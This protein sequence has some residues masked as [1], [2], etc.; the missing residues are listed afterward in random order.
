MHTSYKRP[1]TSSGVVRKR[2]KKNNKK[3]N[4]TKNSTLSAYH[5]SNRKVSSSS[6]T[7]IIKSQINHRQKQ[8]GKWR[9]RKRPFSAKHNIKDIYNNVKRNDDLQNISYLEN[10]LETSTLDMNEDIYNS[11]NNNNKYNSNYYNT[12]EDDMTSMSKTLSNNNY[13]N[14]INFLSDEDIENNAMDMSYFT[15]T[16]TSKPYVCDICKRGFDSKYSMV[17]HRQKLHEHI[18]EPLSP[19]SPDPY[20]YKHNGKDDNGFNNMIPFVYSSRGT[21]QLLNRNKKTPKVFNTSWYVNKNHKNSNITFEE[22]I[23][24][25]NKYIG[26]KNKKLSVSYDNIV[27]SRK[28]NKKVNQQYNDATEQLENMEKN[29]KFSSPSTIN[30][31]HKQQQYQNYFHQHNDNRGNTLDDTREKEKI[32]YMNKQKQLQM[33]RE[34]E[35]FQAIQNREKSL[36]DIQ[37]VVHS[38][39]TRHA[40]YLRKEI[41]NQFRL[42]DVIQLINS[43]LVLRLQTMHVSAKLREWQYGIRVINKASK[44]YN[45]KSEINLSPASDK[46]LDSI[47]LWRGIDYSYKSCYDLAATI[48][49]LPRPLENWIEKYVPLIDNPLLLKGKLTAPNVPPKQLPKRFSFVLEHANKSPIRRRQKQQ[50]DAVLENGQ[51]YAFPFDPATYVAESNKNNVVS[52]AIAWP[53][54]D[55]EEV[56]LQLKIQAA[57]SLAGLCTKVTQAKS[58]LEKKYDFVNS[59]SSFVVPNSSSIVSNARD[60]NK[61]LSPTASVNVFNKRHDIEAI[62]SGDYSYAKEGGKEDHGVNEE[63]TT[64]PSS[65]FLSIT[66]FDDMK[67][68]YELEAAVAKLIDIDHDGKHWGNEIRRGQNFFQEELYRHWL[69]QEAKRIKDTKKFAANLCARAIMHGMTGAHQLIMDKKNRLWAIK[70][71]QRAFRKHLKWKQKLLAAE[72]LA[73]YIHWK[74]RNKLARGLSKFL[75][76]R[77]EKDYKI[78]RAGRNYLRLYRH[79][80]VY[81]CR[82]ADYFT[83]VQ[84]IVRGYFGRQIYKR[85]LKIFKEWTAAH[86]IQ[87]EWKMY[88]TKRAK[89]ASLIQSTYRRYKS[90]LFVDNVLRKERLNV[91]SNDAL[92]LNY[93]DD[94]HVRDTYKGDRPEDRTYIESGLLMPMGFKGNQDDVEPWIFRHHAI[95]KIQKSARKF[96]LRASI[97]KRIFLKQ[98][99]AAALIIQCGYRCYRARVHLHSAL[100]LAY[101]HM[102][103]FIVQNATRKHHAKK[104][105]E[106]KRNKRSLDLNRI[107][108]TD[109]SNDLRLV[110]HRNGVYEDDQ[111]DDDE[112][113]VEIVVVDE[114]DE[115]GNCVL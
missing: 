83:R 3:S 71:L 64:S 95:K 78:K 82:K 19:E 111:D 72:R 47:F 38:L 104:E 94:R 52:N 49:A 81:V 58:R 100:L 63:S 1:K 27:W 40:Q 69:K 92:I 84:A 36:V 76:H 114:E 60:L 66:S 8:A 30:K 44:S 29:N 112:N 107:A 17:C 21:R 20:H 62:L 88:Q 97:K 80:L 24:E 113:G 26:I 73:S 39:H 28:K 108:E 85:R 90:I 14:N 67:N 77:R 96:L 55:C 37:K 23:I 13:N 43:L 89:K 48:A 51:P 75:A 53:D 98:Q 56:P 87:T 61:P 25:E 31:I 15:N 34:S 33:R 18:S 42:N 91:L 102:T 32:I 99:N 16:T 110:R 45:S 7:S 59:S 11:N 105:M 68:I 86:K 79:H 101:F 57:R 12:V 106:D 93:A 65:A 54:D 50:L 4:N 70:H 103:A 5:S 115:D 46:E 35:V 9:R 22:D 109:M 41:D 2:K 6:S 74:N 10:S